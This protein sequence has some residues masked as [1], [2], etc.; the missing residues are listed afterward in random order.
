MSKGGGGDFGDYIAEKP[1]Q[2]LQLGVMAAV[3][4]WLVPAAF[5]G[6][7]LFLL[8]H[9]VL[10]V[11]WYWVL[12]AGFLMLGMV[13]FIE[14]RSTPFQLS[15]IENLQHLLRVGFAHNVLIFKAI[16][17]GEPEAIFSAL[18][19]SLG[20]AGVFSFFI[21]GLL[22][23]L[24]LIPNSAYERDLR[25]L[26]RKQAVARG[27][28]VMGLGHRSSVLER[29]INR[30]VP[31][32]TG[33]RLGVSL[34]TQQAVVVPDETVN[35]MVLV[36]G[37]TG[38][39]KTVTLRRFN[40]HALVQG[41][42][43]IIVDGKPTDENVAWV[44]AVAQQQGRP[45]FG[46]NCGGYDHYDCLA[47]GGYTELKDKLICL[48]EDWA[49]DYYRSIAEDY[50]QTTFEVLLAQP[51]PFDLRTVVDCLDYDTLAVKIRGL[52]DTR[53]VERARRLENYER[54]DI[55]G[56]QAHLNLLIHSELGRFFETAPNLFSLADV[57]EQGGVA[58][59]ALPALRYPTFAKVLGK[60][61]INDIKAVIDRVPVKRLF[62]VFD[63]FSVFAGEPILNLVNMGRG[64]GIHAIFG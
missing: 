53:L 2:A 33:T 41:Y 4:F 62:T 3:A 17:S 43:Q 55:T 25:A 50:L 56:L 48:K 59:F 47:H 61:V 58:Y 21:A 15:F 64:K 45:F 26:Q 8:F 6:L 60:L 23:V 31:P 40:Q 30:N 5:M 10:K 27:Q 42:P 29:V 38:G 12:G 36:L 35:Q 1:R 13:V 57:I 49:S 11:D 24:E 39:G 19:Q 37:T 44:Q 7:I 63:E 28:L 16:F 34:T 22:S 51:E 18:R 52:N 32:P 46:F 20:F 9:R 54:K 14:V